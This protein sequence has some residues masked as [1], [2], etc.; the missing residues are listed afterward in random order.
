MPE[1]GTTAPA[2]I[3]AGFGDPSFPLLL[4]PLA[5]WREAVV[6][7]IEKLRD[8]SIRQALMLPFGT[9]VALL[10]LV[11]WLESSRP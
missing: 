4:A 8:L 7:R 1:P 2:R 3:E 5:R 9:L 6:E 10:V 11:A